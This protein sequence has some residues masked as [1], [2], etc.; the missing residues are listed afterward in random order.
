MDTTRE[1]PKIMVGEGDWIRLFTHADNP[2][3]QWKVREE[4]SMYGG[5]CYSYHDVADCVSM[6]DAATKMHEL[7]N[8]ATS[9]I[10]AR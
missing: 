3:H 6:E 8:A 9:K 10:E 2:Q 7:Y 4:F 1:M 5:R